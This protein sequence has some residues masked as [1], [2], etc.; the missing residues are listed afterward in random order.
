MRGFAPCSLHR[1]LWLQRKDQ[2]GPQAT[3][4]WGSWLLCLCRVH[5]SL[6]M[7]AFPQPNPIFSPSVGTGHS[8]SVGAAPVW[9]APWRS[10]GAQ[11]CFSPALVPLPQ[12][13]YKDVIIHKTLLEV[14]HDG[15]LGDL[16]EQD[17]VVHAALLDIV[18]LPVEALLA[19]LR[20]EGHSRCVGATTDREGTSRTGP[21]PSSHR[22]AGSYNQPL[23]QLWLQNRY[24]RVMGRGAFGLRWEL[25]KAQN[26]TAAA[27]G[28]ARA[29]GLAPR[30]GAD[31]ALTA[32]GHVRNI[33]PLVMEVTKEAVAAGALLMSQRGSKNNPGKGKNCSWWGSPRHRA[34]SAPP[35]PLCTRAEVRLCPITLSSLPRET[36]APPFQLPPNSPGSVLQ[37]RWGSR[38]TGGCD[39]NPGG[40]EHSPN[41]S[42]GPGGEGKI[43]PCKKEK[44]SEPCPPRCRGNSLN[45][46]PLPAWPLVRCPGGDTPW[47]ACPRLLCACPVAPTVLLS[48]PGLPAPISLLLP[49]RHPQPLTLSISLF[50]SSP[51]A[52]FSCWL[53]R[54]QAPGP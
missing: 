6:G 31:G 20:G 21:G 38:K 50:F 35:C 46:A 37:G 45:T 54:F 5:L 25:G 36:P 23:P 43:S 49:P 7:A 29:R 3:A 8:A 4:G 28:L 13:G 14:L 15:L 41:H 19:A 16:G 33:T 34:S 22:A 27:A 18:A 51:F 52:S 11:P 42:P 26:P 1:A 10:R 24:L 30:R 32:C 2:I 53:S 47:G 40:A 9:L 39:L 44:Y 48:P 12:E 17:H